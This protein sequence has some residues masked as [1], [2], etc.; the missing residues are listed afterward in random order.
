MSLPY[1]IEDKDLFY[2]IAAGNTDA[3]R[4]LFTR[5]N[6]RVYAYSLKIT[7][8]AYCAEE[9]TQEVFLKVWLH[10]ADL[11]EIE[12]P[13]AW[14]VTIARNLCYTYLKKTAREACINLDSSDLPLAENMNADRLVEDRDLLSQ[15]QQA[16]RRLSPQQQLVYRLSR[17]EGLRKKEIARVLHISENTVKAHL[18]TALRKIRQNTDAYGSAGA[19][20]LLIIK[21]FIY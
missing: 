12:N 4:Q 1:I 9:I 6:N 11:A 19:L 15:V 21:I 17:E 5:Y 7:R 13:Q 16:A 20:I 10:A 18:T 3:F 14:I 2:G 8:S